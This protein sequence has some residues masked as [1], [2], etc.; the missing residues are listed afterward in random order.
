MRQYANLSN[1]P[2]AKNLSDKRLYGYI[3][4]PSEDAEGNRFKPEDMDF[5]D[6]LREG[7][8][9][10]D[11][12][13]FRNSEA[14]T[15][16]GVPEWIEITPQGVMACFILAKSKPAQDVHEYVRNKPKVLGFSIAGGLS[17]TMF[18]RGGKWRVLCVGIS[19]FPINGGS[20]AKAL[21]LPSLGRLLNVM[22]ALSLDLSRGVD[23]DFAYFSKRVDDPFLAASLSI[24]AKR[25]SGV[26]VMQAQVASSNWADIYEG[27]FLSPDESKEAVNS[28]LSHWSEWLQTHPQDVHF[29]KT[30][31]L[32]SWD[33]AVEHLRHCEG[34]S[35]E[36]IAT[37]LG[38]LR[39]DFA[40]YL[41]DPPPPASWAEVDTS[42]THQGSIVTQP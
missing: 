5:E 2:H 41:K 25:L 28:I 29:S 40:N 23:P 10:I 34:L 4:L 31:R 22:R 26:K 35:K 37:I 17:K 3:T 13:M 14:D 1:N 8:L 15:I 30:G 21:S 42:A 38:Y 20:A 32:R 27:L 24:W 36:Q 39:E 33:D 7:Y 6:F 19:R 11:H 9:D 18:D 12:L 16:I